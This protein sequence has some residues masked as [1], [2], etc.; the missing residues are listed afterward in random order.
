MNYSELVEASV[1][2]DPPSP[3]YLPRSDDIPAEAQWIS[4][5]ILFSREELLPNLRNILRIP[6]EEFDDRL[7][8]SC[9][10]FGP[11]GSSHK[12][13][14]TLPFWNQQF[15][16]PGRFSCLR[17]SFQCHIGLANLGGIEGPQFEEQTADAGWITS[18]RSPQ[19]LSGLHARRHAD[20]LGLVRRRASI[21][22]NNTSIRFI[23]DG[24]R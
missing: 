6:P 17:P 12:L 18:L 3:S 11:D 15:G 1:E 14:S 13:P 19:F 8:F 9:Q 7:L 2:G 4:L 5:V 21:R 22:C 16:V 10:R 20:L 23:R 24:R